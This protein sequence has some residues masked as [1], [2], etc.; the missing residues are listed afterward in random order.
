M[1]MMTM[2]RRQACWAYA[3]WQVILA[4]N[5]GQG[6]IALQPPLYIA[7]SAPAGSS[8]LDVG[9]ANGGETGTGPS[10]HLGQSPERSEGVIY[11]VVAVL[12]STHHCTVRSATAPW[13][14]GGATLRGLAA[15]V[16]SVRRRAL[17][18]T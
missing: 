1:I 9:H 15:F 4:A 2:R 18:A 12:L 16:H 17:P 7:K 11:I 13:G 14:G 8:G 10:P 5:G 6:C 3:T